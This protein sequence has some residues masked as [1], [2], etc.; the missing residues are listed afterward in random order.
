MKE[1]L[2]LIGKRLLKNIRLVAVVFFALLLGASFYLSSK[3]SNFS[4]PVPE[5]PAPQAISNKFAGET[6]NANYSLL[7]SSFVRQST[8]ISQDARLS[9]LIRVNMFDDKSVASEKEMEEAVRD[10]YLKAQ[11]AFTDGKLDDAMRLLES[12]LQRNP[13][14]RGSLEI[15]RKIEE[16][17]AA[18]AAAAA[19]GQP[20]E[21]APPADGQPVAQ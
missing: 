7:M 12:I 20:T 18:E 1:K 3:E 9:R 5:P 13:T 10:D 19:A 17:R 21:G 11:Q 14:H 2:E 6:A 15:K 16:R 8:D 4:D